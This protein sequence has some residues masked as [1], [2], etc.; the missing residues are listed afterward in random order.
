MISISLTYIYCAVSWIC[1]TEILSINRIFGK[2]GS[3]RIDLDSSQK[4][5]WSGSWPEGI[6]LVNNLNKKSVFPKASSFQNITGYPYSQ[7]SSV[8][9]KYA[10]PRRTYT[11]TLQ[12]ELLI[13]VNMSSL[14]NPTCTRLIPPLTW[15][16]A[17]GAKIKVLQTT[18]TINNRS[19]KDLIKSV[20]DNNNLN[21]NNYIESSAISSS[22]VSDSS[23]ILPTSSSESGSRFIEI[24]VRKGIVE[25]SLS[26]LR[27]N[28]FS[29]E[30]IFRMLDKGP[31]VLAF[32][33]P[34]TLPRLCNDLQSALGANQTQ[35][36]HII[37]HCPYLLA[38][39]CRYKGKDL[40]STVKALI[41]LGYSS[42][43]L[44]NDILRFPSMLSAP[45][46]RLLGWKHL[47]AAYNIANGKGE[48]GK[49]IKRAP[50]MFY[51]NPPQIFDEDFSSHVRNANA[52][53]AEYIVYDSLAVL[54]LLCDLKLK[55]VEKI[56]RTDP[57]LLL[58]PTKEVKSRIVYILNL[59]TDSLRLPSNASSNFKNNNGQDIITDHDH[60][61]NDC[62]Y[63]D[64]FGGDIQYD[65]EKIGFKNTNGEAYRLLVNLV[66]TYPAVLLTELSQM[67]TVVNTLLEAGFRESDIVRLLKL[68]PPLLE[69]G[70][71][72]LKGSIYFLKQYCGF[73]KSELLTLLK[74][75]P[76]VLGAD[77][78]ELQPK[79]DYLCKSL[80]SSPKILLKHPQYLS[81]QLDSH[82]RPRAELI[83]AL[84]K[85]PLCNGLS[86]L[87]NTSDKDFA[88]IIGTTL[89]IYTKYR[90]MFQEKWKKQYIANNKEFILNLK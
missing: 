26:V 56:I 2:F 16:G 43:N 15:L 75:H 28:G 69:K 68:Y 60:D 8:R 6:K 88:Y 36:V 48:F 4:V 18:S 46:D 64:M 84:G 19:F 17:T 25:E 89:D 31:W 22:S 81:Y 51:L 74:K 54:K 21:S 71:I 80:N 70:S 79:V 63:C 13:S 7:Q 59:F 35:M 67:K 5:R 39:F 23:N 14:S 58:T 52:S 3:V 45:P 34:Q 87:T 12:D 86:F 73:S 57:I 40:Q 76:I 24:T 53:A 72:S 66:E 29:R 27:M 62:E 1:F 47:M 32:N 65:L 30:D 37:S 55:N 44:M 20:D 61:H 41:E 10:V 11:W 33:I 42:H 90:I 85:D 78:S 82:I 38:Q 77:I 50:F 9:T 49:F 83:R